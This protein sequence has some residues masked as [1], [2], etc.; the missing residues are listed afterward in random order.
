[1]LAPQMG[2]PRPVV[3]YRGKLDLV[4]L[5]YWAG[6]FI[7]VALRRRQGNI[8]IHSERE[9][10]DDLEWKVKDRDATISALHQKPVTDAAP[11]PTPMH[12]TTAHLHAAHLHAAHLHA[13]H[14]HAAHLHAAHLHAAHLPLACCTLACCTLSGHCWFGIYSPSWLF[15]LFSPVRDVV[16]S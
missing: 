6:G 16:T 13:T 11:T 2:F 9:R 12:H 1:M 10:I 4:V 3:H 5:L 15:D 8:S 14:L 7:G